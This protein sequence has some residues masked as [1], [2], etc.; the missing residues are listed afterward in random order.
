M[1]KK[2]RFEELIQKYS[3][4]ASA[5][6]VEVDGREIKEMIQLFRGIAVEITD[7]H[8]EQLEVLKDRIAE[9][10]GEEL[11][12]IVWADG[13]QVFHRAFRG[14]GPPMEFYDAIGDRSKAVFL[15]RE[16]IEQND[17]GDDDTWVGKLQ[18]ECL[19]RIRGLSGPG[20]SETYSS[21]LSVDVEVEDGD[22]L[23]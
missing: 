23:D 7:G 9:I 3:N 16:L 1:D 11:H 20:G 21:A 12:L 13:G 14:D 8:K 22:D 15:I 5:D 10:E 4:I 19:K 17:V 6:G 18:D 2:E